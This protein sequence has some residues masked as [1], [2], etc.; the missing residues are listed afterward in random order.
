MINCSFFFLSPSVLYKHSPFTVVK[1][2]TRI[3]IWSRRPCLKQERTSDQPTQVTGSHGCNS[4]GFVSWNRVS[5]TPKHYTQWKY[6]CVRVCMSSL[7]KELNFN[8]SMGYS[9]HSWYTS[10]MKVHVE[11]ACVYHTD[12]MLLMRHKP[13]LSIT[14]AHVSFSDTPLV[15]MKSKLQ[16]V[17]IKR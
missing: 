8:V 11:F 5:L 6:V 17:T 15:G 3:V 13:P 2:G 10:R 12:K 4:E 9:R 16:L 7:I 14:K 1:Q